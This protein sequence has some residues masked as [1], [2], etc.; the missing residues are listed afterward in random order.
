[1]VVLCGTVAAQPDDPRRREGGYIG[2]DIPVLEIDDCRPA[3]SANPQVEAGEHF[4]RGKLLYE[5]GDYKGAVVELVSAYCLSPHYLPLMSIGQA[6]ERM[7]E[8]EKAIAYFERFVF[9]VPKDAKP[10]NACDPDPQDEKKLIAARIHVLENLPAKIRVNTEP[11]NAHIIIA[12]EARVAADERSGKEI[13]VLGGRYRMTIEKEGFQTVTREIV[14][15]VGK[16]YTFFEKLEPKRGRLRVH[17]NPAEARLFVDKL[18]VGT[19]VYE[20]ALPGG[21][22]TISAEA[23]D[24]VTST[25]DVEVIADRDTTINVD[26]A[27]VPQV[28]RR[29]LVAYATLAGG[30]AGGTLI[31]A[32]SNGL[33]DVIGVGGGMAGGFLAAYFAA[34]ERVPLGTSSLTIT[35]SFF[36]GIAG[37][38]TASIFTGDGNLISPAI[39][40]GLVLGA[41]LGYYAGQKFEVRPGDAALVNSGALWGTV[42]GG[43]FAISFDS[44]ADHR[45]IDSGIV[46]SGLGLG[47]VAGALLAH[48]YT[49][50]RGRA[51]LIDASGVL[52]IVLGLAVNSVASRAS[53]NSSTG[54]S[55]ERTSNFALGG[56]AVGL[57]AGGVLTR[58]MDEPQVTVS[59]VM[60]RTSNGTATFGLGATW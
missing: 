46:L 44:N 33:Y 49:V 5:Q 9:A 52:G 21:K 15:E 35:S 51:A 43:L 22:Y 4:E 57:I 42:A 25:R 12:N 50:S 54:G 16:P 26:L 31:G 55:D 36:G 39:G 32:Q 7:L 29:Q 53:T 41:G 28:G 45:S 13:E 2:R 34:D 59:P 20:A 19:G 56:L 24:F 27:P 58:H 14:A 60:G 18:Q 10:L 6:Y 38:A 1:V 48:N 11:A 47:T 17:V 40:G 23:P 3:S 30:V 37:A 8:Y